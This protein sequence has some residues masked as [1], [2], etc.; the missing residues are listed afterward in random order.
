MEELQEGLLFY[1]ITIGHPSRARFLRGLE[2][3]DP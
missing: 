3:G 1:P 2:E